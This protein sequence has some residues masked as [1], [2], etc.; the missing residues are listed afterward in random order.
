MSVPVVETYGQSVVGVADTS[1]YYK[2]L[3]VTEGTKDLIDR[4]AYDESQSA[5]AIVDFSQHVF[6]LQLEKHLKDYQAG[7]AERS[8]ETASEL[9]T[10]DIQN[11][12][13]L[14]RAATDYNKYSTAF[15]YERKARFVAG[16]AESQ[17]H[18][19]R[20]NQALSSQEFTGKTI[21]ITL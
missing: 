7:H 9:R 17:K 19:L 6:R 11:S 5:A 16:V 1:S 20:L 21:D 4:M 12:L 8:T 10:K 13:G 14:G 3:S 18:Q 2:P 15:S